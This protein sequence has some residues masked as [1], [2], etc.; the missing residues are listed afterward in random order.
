MSD[1]YTIKKLRKTF[2]FNKD[3]EGL[4]TRYLHEK[5]NWQ[6]HIENTKKYILSK[7]REEQRGRDILVREFIPTS[8]NRMNHLK[9][10]NTLQTF[11]NLVDRN[12]NGIVTHILRFFPKCIDDLIF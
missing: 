3:R 7:N 11:T 2:G 9:T 1:Y 12:L 4:I 10:K 5:H 8:T 6:K